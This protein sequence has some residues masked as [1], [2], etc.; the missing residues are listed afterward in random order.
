MINQARQHRVSKPGRGK[1][2][3]IIVNPYVSYLTNGPVFL[4]RQSGDHPILPFAGK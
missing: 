2:I 3:C 4:G 1:I